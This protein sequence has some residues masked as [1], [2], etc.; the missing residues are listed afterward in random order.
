M[1][2]VVGKSIGTLGVV[3]SRSR[4]PTGILPA[5]LGP[6]I[7]FSEGL[8]EAQNDLFHS[9]INDLQRFAGPAC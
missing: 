4:R 6:K 9:R 7:A 8:L 2:R 5:R 1:R 3:L